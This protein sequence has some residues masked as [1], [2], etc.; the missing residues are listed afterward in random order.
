MDDLW[1]AGL[2]PREERT[3]GEHL[4][5]LRKIAFGALKKLGVQL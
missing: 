1:N 2:R 5:D 3:T 4:S